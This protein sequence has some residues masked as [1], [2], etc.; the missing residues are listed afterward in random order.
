MRKL[1]LKINDKDYTLEL[2]R[3]SIKWLESSGFDIRNLAR[4]GEMFYLDNTSSSNVKSVLTTL[5]MN[6]LSFSDMS[7]KIEESILSE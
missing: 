3:S 4:V 2:N 6:I 5:L 1:K 7:P